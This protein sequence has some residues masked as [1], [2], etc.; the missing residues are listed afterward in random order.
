MELKPAYTLSFDQLA[1]CFN[2]AFAGYVGGDIH[3]TAAALAGWIASEGIDLNLSQIVLRDGQPAGFG[4]IVRQGGECRLAAFGI[5]PSA[6]HQ[7]VGKAAMLELIAQARARADSAFYLEVIEQNPRAV[8]LYQGVGFEIVR[9]LIGC[10]A[11]NPQQAVGAR[12]AAPDLAQIDLAVGVSHAAPDLAQIDLAVGARHASPYLQ[13][14]D[15]YTAAQ[16]VI[17]Y[18]SRDLP[19]QIGGLEML[20]LSPPNVA[21]RLGDAIAILSNPAA[22]TI[23]IRSLIVNP[24]FRHQGQATRLL[25]ALFTQF[26]S[27][28]WVASP[29]FPEAYVSGLAEKFGFTLQPISQWQ[30]RLGL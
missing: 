2:T 14:I 10:K 3:F 22:E 1:D 29:I 7:G 23:S 13:Q 21:Y 11:A 18:A 24:E 26:P 12:H 27:K 9:R 25:G 16:A 28:T 5:V 30:M 17:A 15:L 6:A 19:W 4:Y 8:K 20:R